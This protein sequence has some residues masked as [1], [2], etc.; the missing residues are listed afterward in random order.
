MAGLLP[1][2]K[3]FLID[4]NGDPAVGW[5]IYTYEAGT[6]TPKATYTDAAAGTSN[7]NPVV[8]DARGEADIWFDGTYNIT[9]TDASDVTVYTA[10]NYSHGNITLGDNDHLYLGDGNDLDLYH[11]AANSYIDNSVGALIMQVLTTSG[12]L[13][14]RTN[15]SVDAIKTLLEL[16]GTTPEVKIF[17]NGTQVANSSSSGLDLA[18]G[19][20][21]SADLTTDDAA[22]INFQATVDGDATSAISN[23]TTSGA[24]TH[25]IQVEINGVTAWI[26]C[27]TTDPT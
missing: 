27:S 2:P 20:K 14:M 21:L 6:T 7:T 22:F 13:R 25:H 19:K 15:D 17:H 4:N 16:G 26:P 18:A 9:V 10:D 8:L 23:L 11:D 12:I 24:V 5:K 1:N 3:F